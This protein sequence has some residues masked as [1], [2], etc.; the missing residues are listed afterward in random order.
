MP[1]AALA[2]VQRL[3]SVFSWL[4]VWPAVSLRWA[5]AKAHLKRQ[6]E[7]LYEEDKISP[8][9]VKTDTHGVVLW[10]TLPEP[11]RQAG[12]CACAGVISPYFVCSPSSFVMTNRTTWMPGAHANESAAL[13]GNPRGRF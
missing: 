10:S 12:V 7:F 13:F 11:A 6:R 8:E 4:I 2:L 5:L 1:P 3:V 9:Y